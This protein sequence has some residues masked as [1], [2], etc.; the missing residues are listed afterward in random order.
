VCWALKEAQMEDLIKKQKADI[1]SQVGE[2][3]IRISGGQK[4][5]LGIARALYFG[6][7]ILIFDEATSALDQETEQMVMN[8]I[9]KLKKKY[10]LIVVA[11]R[12]S[13]LKVCDRIYNLSLN[14]LVFTELD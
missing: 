11:H 12:L 3:G 9:A 7:K 13:T 8:N 6:A 2:R 5:R 14:G 4:Q 1:D 10:T